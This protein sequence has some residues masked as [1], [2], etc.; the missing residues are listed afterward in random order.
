MSHVPQELHEAFPEKAEAISRLKSGDAMFQQM[1]ERFDK[2]DAAVKAAEA[3][4]DP[5]SDE[6]LEDMK[7]HRLAVLDEIA[8]YLDGPGAA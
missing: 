4:D 1:T 6:R 5:A 7:K 8:A 3:G 2:A